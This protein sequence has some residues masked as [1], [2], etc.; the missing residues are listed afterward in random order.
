MLATRGVLERQSGFVLAAIFSAL[1]TDE[2]GVQLALLRSLERLAEDADGAH[3]IRAVGAAA[4][5]ACAKV[6]I[7][8]ET[9]AMRNLQ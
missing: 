7:G 8:L 6:E 4:V 1:H 9:H 2:M 5:V 3:E